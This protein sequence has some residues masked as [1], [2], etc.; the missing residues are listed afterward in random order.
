MHTVHIEHSIR[1]YD[2][3]KAAF[4]SDPVGR[5]KS[6]VVSYRIL[7]PT[8]DPL[9][10]S[11]DLDFESLERAESFLAAMRQVWTRVE[12]TVMSNLQTRIAERVE[13]RDI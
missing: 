5:Q 8:D 3:W 1:S 12:G 11:I 6:G 13:S 2:H 10:V 9:C 4:E 7:R